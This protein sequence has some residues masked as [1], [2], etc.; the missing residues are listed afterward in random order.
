MDYR[1]ERNHQTDY[2]YSDITN[3]DGKKVVNL[4]ACF[5]FAIRAGV[6]DFVKKSFTTEED[7]ELISRGQEEGALNGNTALHKAESHQHVLNIALDLVGEYGK[8]K[9]K[10]LGRFETPEDAKKAVEDESNVKYAFYVDEYDVRD[11]NSH[12]MLAE[13]DGTI[14]F[15][16]YPGL[17]L[18]ERESR[19]VFVIVE[20]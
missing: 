18:T 9:G 1:I 16:P 13:E 8:V 3:S 4:Y 14:V 15:D 2:R 20:G 6:E 10:Y 5:V 12:F 7:R 17:D 19:R 11:A